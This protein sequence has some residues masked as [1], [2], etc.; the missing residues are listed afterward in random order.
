MRLAHG[1]LGGIRWATCFA[2]AVRMVSRVHDDATNLGPLTHMSGAP[3]CPGSGS[4]AR[5]WRPADRPMHRAGS[6]GPRPME[7]ERGVVALFGEELA[8]T[9]LTGRS[10]HPCRTS[11]MLW[12]VVPSGCWPAAGVADAG[13]DLDAGDDDVSTLSLGRSM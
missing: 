5:D 7:V 4:H 3:P 12:I 1:V 10:G 2:T 11:S 8:D 13:L 9:R 6:D